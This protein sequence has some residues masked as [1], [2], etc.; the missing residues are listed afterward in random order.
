M[1][2]WGSFLRELDIAADDFDGDDSISININIYVYTD[3]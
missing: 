2:F 3:A 1:I